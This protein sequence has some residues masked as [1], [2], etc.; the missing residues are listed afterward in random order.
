MAA[1]G[2]GLYQ[3]REVHR[4]LPIVVLLAVGLVGCLPT[5]DRPPGDRLDSGASLNF[6][7]AVMDVPPMDVPAIDRPVVVDVG[8]DVGARDVQP[9]GDGPDPTRRYPGGPYGLAPPAI[10]QPFQVNDCGGTLYR[11]DGSDWIPAWGTVV[12]LTNGYC[13][14]CDDNA[15]LL[16]RSVVRPYQQEGIRFVTVLVDGE[17]PGEPADMNFCRSWAASMGIVGA[18]APPHAMAI[19]FGGM[20]RLHS[21]PPLTLPQWILTDE[22]G[23]ILWR[24]AGSEQSATMLVGQIRDLLG[25]GP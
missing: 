7:V 16:Q 4:R 5:P 10:M 13:A 12:Q 21:Q 14:G 8:R 22:N 25:L 17:T 23:R 3:R 20:L 19:D 6:D 2:V 15:R 1:R 24:G 9:R 18:G 11:F